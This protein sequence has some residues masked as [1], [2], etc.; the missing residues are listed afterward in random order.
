MDEGAIADYDDTR[1]AVRN[2][3]RKAALKGDDPRKAARLIFEIANASQ[4]RLRYAI[5]GERWLPYLR[6]FLPQRAFDYLLSRGFKLS[7][8]QGGHHG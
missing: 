3:F 1:R 2:I 6:V 5:G 4:P 8:S 7:R